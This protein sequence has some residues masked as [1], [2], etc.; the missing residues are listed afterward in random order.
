[1]GGDIY[2]EYSPLYLAACAIDKK[3][4]SNFFRDEPFPPAVIDHTLSLAKKMRPTVD[5]RGLNDPAKSSASRPI[6]DSRF[7][8]LE[9]DPRFRLPARKQT[10]VKLDKRFANI[11]N[12]DD[13]SRKASV[14]RYG[15]KIEKGAGKK[16]LERLY[17]L[18]DKDEDESERS[19]ED[20]EIVLEELQRI[21]RKY[22]P[23]REGGFSESSSE[24]ESSEDEDEALQGVQEE[25]ELAQDGGAKVPMGE[26]S[27]RLA[28]VNLDWD[29]IQAVDLMAVASSFVPAEGRIFSVT[30]YP[31]EFGKQR[32][33][34]E[35]LEGPPREIFVKRKSRQG[36]ASET[37]S[38]EEDERIKK[39]LLQEDKG[40]EFD[41]TALRR[42][43]IDRLRYYYAVI[44]C[45]S[46]NVAKALYDDMDGREYLSSANFFDL[47]FIPDGV[48]FDNDETRDTCSELPDGYKPTEFVTEALT[49]SNVKLTWDADDGK[50]KEIQKRAFSRKEIDDNNLQAY[51][52]SASSSEE[53]E[54]EAIEPVDDS[55]DV[56][57]ITSKATT[58]ADRRDALR[59]ALGL[60]PEPVRPSK[61][62]KSNDKPVGDMQVTF[63]PALTISEKK[64][65]VFE[66]GPV[67]DE[68]TRDKY[69]RTEKE[70]KQ[71]RRE[72]LHAVRD[73]R[74][75]DAV[76][77]SSDEEEEEMQAF[78]DADEEDPFNDPFFADPVA[79]EKEAKKT[80]KADRARLRAECEA[81]EKA[82]AAQKAE[83][84]LL[85]DNDS[86]LRHF[87]MKEIQRTEKLSK[88]KHKRKGKDKTLNRGTEN[89]TDDGFK[90]NVQDPRFS[91][92]FESH[93][94]A[95]DPTNARYKETQGMKQLLEES[96][97]K[98][99]RV[100]DDGGRS[101]HK[102]K[103]VKGPDDLTV[104]SDD[105]RALVE[106][107]KKKTKR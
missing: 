45:S 98:R 51:I 25:A 49:H 93:E 104:K 34:R 15:R 57:S 99:A 54:D 31:S 16:E 1:M 72:R 44:E 68:T 87:D 3:V 27:T 14:D 80:S 11:L 81:E 91:R 78:S 23:A 97:K 59:A 37:D 92:L 18:E 38:D 48:G 52:G 103:R 61:K 55:A 5:Q 20:D 100:E 105:L 77:S 50:R 75:L 53:E 35:E 29:N 65:A 17:K 66:N 2:T 74:E 102:V 67:P 42:Y 22:D 64:G 82:A 83:L 95:I 8:R 47:R 43:Q 56:V 107:V 79:A 13:F 41:S 4:L 60:P 40:D 24:E 12:D 76:A 86:K 39:Q 84:E 85:M 101:E 94:F 33:Q 46:K 26:V 30:V 89:G 63:T 70:R 28:C 32:M 10:H 71:R 21:D 73:G 96:R 6:A 69:V 36:D 7:T 19:G 88:K 106:K 9:T 62:N 90:M 58:K